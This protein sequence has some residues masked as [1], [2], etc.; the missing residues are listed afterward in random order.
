[1]PF[2]GLS[3]P[4]QQP[5]GPH[6]NVGDQAPSLNSLERG[7]LNLVAFLR[8]TGCPFAEYA[9]KQLSAL[10]E[11]NPE[12][13]VIAI[14]HGD[15]DVA[16]QWLERIG[17]ST[18]LQVILDE[19]R[20]LYGSWGI[21]YVKTRTLLHPAVLPRLLV[22]LAKGIRNRDAS[23]TRW[24][25]QG[26]FLVDSEGS[27]LWQHRPAHVGEVPDLHKILLQKNRI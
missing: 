16:Y 20:R 15:A 14:L 9:V 23:G 13:N 1:M 22:L 4:P 5:L 11:Q 18:K 27:I 26:F 24:Q 25:E 6:L 21:G 3:K 12:L 19:Q 10:A 2:I 17:A 7:K 8:H